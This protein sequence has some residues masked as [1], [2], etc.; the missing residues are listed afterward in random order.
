M[1]A[2][3]IFFWAVI[4]VANLSLFLRAD[5]ALS[6]A[7][8]QARDATID[9][10][11]APG[12]MELARSQILAWVSTAVEAVTEYFGQFPVSHARIIIKPVAGRSGVLSGM[13]WGERGALTRI[14]LGQ[15]TSQSQLDDDWMMTHELV[16]MAFPDVA[17]QGREHHWMEEGMATYIE[18]IARAQ[19]AK[20]TVEKVWGDMVRFMPQGLPREGDQGLDYTHTWGRTYWGGA[21]YWWLADIRIRECTDNQRGLQD[22]MRTILRAGGNIE[23]EWPVARVLEVGDK[24]TGCEVL[25]NL[26]NQMKAAPVQTDLADLWRRLG[27]EVGPG[28]LEFNDEAPLAKIRKAIT[29]KTAGTWIIH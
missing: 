3:R 9:V 26:Y 6:P 14:S 7:Q 17:G 18:P 21:L 28:S 27:I 24:G 16:H 8:I 25:G 11:F 1:R 13:T 4:G 5:D 29:A 15:F 23:H 2:S 22:A 19:I 10:T 12:K 20:L